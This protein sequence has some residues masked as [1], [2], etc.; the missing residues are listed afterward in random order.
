MSAKVSMP[1]SHAGMYQIGYFQFRE[2]N[3]RVNGKIRTFPGR[4]SF[5]NRPTANKSFCIM[6]VIVIY[7]M[8]TM[9]RYPKEI[10]SESVKHGCTKFK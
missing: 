5:F 6:D 8:A 2:K 3:P 1:H 7:D 9:E 4:L 10:R